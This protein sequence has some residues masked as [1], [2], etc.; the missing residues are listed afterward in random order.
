MFAKKKARY[1]DRRAK[2]IDDRHQEIPP[3]S[4]GYRISFVREIERWME[5][6]NAFLAYLRYYDA[7]GCIMEW[8]LEVREIGQ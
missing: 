2:R 5:T 3:I 6:Y 7:R 8:Q 1:F 4:E